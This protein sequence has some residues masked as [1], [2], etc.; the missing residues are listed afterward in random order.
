MRVLAGSL[1]QQVRT[2]RNVI[3]HPLVRQR[4]SRCAPARFGRFSGAACTGGSTRWAH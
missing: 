4:S 3:S 1:E 2:I